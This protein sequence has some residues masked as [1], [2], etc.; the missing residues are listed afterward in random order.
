MLEIFSW[1]AI[2]ISNDTE[3]FAVKVLP[4]IG[5]EVRKLKGIGSLSCRRGFLWSWLT[6]AY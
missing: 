6:L 5:T 1:E 4:V 2:F 3:V